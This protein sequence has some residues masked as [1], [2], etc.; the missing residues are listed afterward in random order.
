[1]PSPMSAAWIVSTRTDH[2]MSSQ[3]PMV[4]ASVAWEAE[5]QPP[6]RRMFPSSGEWITFTR[7][8][9]R[10]SITR[11]KGSALWWWGAIDSR[12]DES[13]DCKRLA[14]TVKENTAARKNGEEDSLEREKN[15]NTKK[16]RKGGGSKLVY[17]L[18]LFITLNASVLK[19]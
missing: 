16:T 1:M 14:S 19:L 12:D 11:I 3:A 6:G 2:A 18:C 17:H 7:D 15:Q 10:E 9:W 8:E 5:D 4:G 13:C